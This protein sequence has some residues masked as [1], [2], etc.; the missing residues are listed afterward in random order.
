MTFSQ[1][2]ADL[3]NGLTFGWLCKPPPRPAKT[4]IRLAIEHYEQAQLELLQQEDLAEYHN[5]MV[6]VLKSR[7]KRLRADITRLSSEDLTPKELS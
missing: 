1:F 5:G 7:I 6:T 3:V 4:A 2:M